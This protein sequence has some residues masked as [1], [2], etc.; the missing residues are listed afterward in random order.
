MTYL[1]I[2]YASIEAINCEYMLCGA[3]M[4]FPSAK[5]KIH[6][7]CVHIDFWSDEQQ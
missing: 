4:V 6:N 2:R 5:I 1:Y 3:S 7:F